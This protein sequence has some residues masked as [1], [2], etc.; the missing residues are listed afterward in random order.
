MTVTKVFVGVAGLVLLAAA[1]SSGSDTSASTTT[2]TTEV[3]TTDTSGDDVEVVDEDFNLL[4]IVPSGTVTSA[5]AKNSAYLCQFSE[6]TDHSASWI[7]DDGTLV[8]L[9]LKPTVPGEVSWDSELSIVDEGDTRPVVGN[10]LPTNP[11]GEY[12]IPSDSEA[13]E[14]DRN[15]NSIE[16]Q[17]IS[18]SL[19]LDPQVAAEPS[20]LGQGAIAIASSGAV[21]FNPVDADGIIA[22]ANEIL[23]GCRGHPAPGGQYHYHSD[24]PVCLDHGDATGHSPLVGYALDGFGVYGHYG[25]DG[26]LVTNA[27]LDECHGH[28]DEVAWDGDQVEIYHYHTNSEFPFVLGCYTGTPATAA[29]GG[30]AGVGPPG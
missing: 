28:T 18:W 8:D 16:A 9:S 20:C 15:P 19:P 17:S 3:A 10:G 30:G 23:D 22:A 5:P 27:E 21:F 11:T 1:C 12:P 13:Y 4:T 6:I 26:E 14:F 7:L 29:A 24:S 2:T 25:T